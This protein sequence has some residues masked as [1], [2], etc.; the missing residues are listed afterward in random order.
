MLTQEAEKLL[1]EILEHENDSN[2]WENKYRGLTMK[3]NTII[4]G[5]FGE[6]EAN[7]LIKVKWADNIP[8]YIQILKDGY[9]Y[10]RNNKEETTSE[11]KLYLRRLIEDAERIISNPD[12]SYTREDWLNDAEIFIKT[13]LL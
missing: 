12:N 7:K 13:N 11:E 10:Q 8:Y 3:E 5:C 9:L 2:Y 1:F 4:S 6:L